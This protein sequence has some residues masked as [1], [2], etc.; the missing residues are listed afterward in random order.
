MTKTAAP[1]KPFFR[2]P[3]RKPKEPELKIG[4]PSL[5]QQSA[6]LG[7]FSPPQSPLSATSPPA[8]AATYNRPLK[9]N[10]SPS[11]KSVKETAPATQAFPSYCTVCD[12][13][14]DSS[15]YSPLYCSDSCKEKDSYSTGK[16]MPSNSLL[17]SSGGLRSD[18]ND[19][20]FDFIA[21]YA[22]K[23]PRLKSPLSSARESLASLDISSRESMS[24]FASSKR[25]GLRPPSDPFYSPTFSPQQQPRN[26]PGDFI[27]EI[28]PL[29]TSYGPGGFMVGEQSLPPPPPSFLSSLARPYPHTRHSNPTA[30]SDKLPSESLGYLRR[31]PS[32]PTTSSTLFGT[33]GLG[34]SHL[35]MD[36]T[37]SLTGSFN[38]STSTANGSVKNTSSLDSTQDSTDNENT[39]TTLHPRPRRQSFYIRSGR[40]L[41]STTTTT[42]LTPQLVGP[43]QFAK[44]LAGDPAVHCNRHSTNGSY[45]LP[46][47]PRS[48]TLVLPQQPPTPVAHEFE[49]EFPRPMSPRESTVDSRT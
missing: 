25:F 7:S 48:I 35:P 41:Y 42:P 24:S 39:N 5:Q 37:V 44:Q 32:F 26:D 27:P 9:N 31:K 22:L 14:I 30:G 49:Y 13:L 10:V 16:F 36:L 19:D 4:Y 23:S 46:D 2:Q 21:P 33:S 20:E 38:Y 43:S 6:I 18:D 45:F 11:T 34:I 8:M 12:T 47:S 3:P 28:P 1:V 15:A 40:H 29:S 17:L